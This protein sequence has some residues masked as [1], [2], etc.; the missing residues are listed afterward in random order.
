M[1]DIFV[2]LSVSAGIRINAG[3]CKTSESTICRSEICR[4]SFVKLQ[5]IDFRYLT[6]ILHMGYEIQLICRDGMYSCASSFTVRYYLNKMIHFP[7]G[8]PN[9]TVYQFI[10]KLCSVLFHVEQTVGLHKIRYY[11]KY[12]TSN[13]INGWKLRNSLIKRLT[14]QIK[15]SISKVFFCISNNF[16][17]DI[18]C[19]NVLTYYRLGF[20]KRISDSLL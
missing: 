16:L 5:L 8:I 14:L 15:F 1:C 6:K 19:S 9:R 11:R 7:L 4:F 17:K 2:E 20:F 18:L 3:F 10:S 13:K 12:S